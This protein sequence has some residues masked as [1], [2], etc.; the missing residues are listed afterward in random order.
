MQYDNDMPLDPF[1]GEPLPNHMRA[2]RVCL[3]ASD[4]VGEIV[5]APEVNL[6]SA[7]LYSNAMRAMVDNLYYEA[8]Y[9]TYR[10]EPYQVPEPVVSALRDIVDVCNQYLD[11]VGLSGAPLEEVHEH[12]ASIRNTS[13]L[14]L[15][16]LDAY[17]EEPLDPKGLESQLFE[18]HLVTN[19]IDRHLSRIAKLEYRQSHG[20]QSAAQELSSISYDKEGLRGVVEQYGKSYSPITMAWVDAHTSLGYDMDGPLSGLSFAERFV[21]AA[22]RQLS[23]DHPIDAWE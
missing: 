12:R 2:E 17:E 10:P 16:S 19:Y 18:P 13:P 22:S 9:D 8:S 23:I 5:S 1:A 21:A 14:D 20:D 7:A 4:V 6:L 11:T 3:D 15:D